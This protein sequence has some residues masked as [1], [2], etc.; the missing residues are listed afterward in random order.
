MGE[1]LMALQPPD[2][3]EKKFSA[4]QVTILE[5][6]RIGSPVSAA[7][8]AAGVSKTT[9]YRWMD[10]KGTFRDAAYK[11]VKRSARINNLR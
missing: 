10:Q 4:A 11:L 3:T 7:W 6:I 2:W 5:A 8:R 1:S 9:F